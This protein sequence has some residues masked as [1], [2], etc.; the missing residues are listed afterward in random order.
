MK[1]LTTIT[2]WQWMSETD[3]GAP[4]MTL[5]TLMKNVNFSVATKLSVAVKLTQTCQ[6][7]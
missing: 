4:L 5:M 1:A 2:Y 3:G 7:W 6:P